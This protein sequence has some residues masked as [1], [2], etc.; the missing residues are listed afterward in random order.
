[1]LAPAGTG[2]LYVRRE[3]RDR[4]RSIFSS[5]A[6][7][8]QPRLGPPG[9]APFPVL[10]AIGH[11]LDF[12]DGLGLSAVEARCRFL[13]DHLKARLA[14]TTGVTLLSGERGLSC[15]GSTIFERAGLDAMA[16][17]PMLAELAG[18]HI[19]E[20][21]RDGHNAIRVS[22]HIYNTTEDVDRVVDVLNREVA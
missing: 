5:D 10:A 9:T 17:V 16:A 12:M 3:A 1:M 13:S 11:A 6:A 8:E 4:V 21:Q 14:E 22:T 7:P 15:P 19:D 18:A 20:H 2:F